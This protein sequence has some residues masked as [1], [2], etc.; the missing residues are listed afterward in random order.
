M[1]CSILYY[2]H[3]LVITVACL[4]V[5]A[6]ENGTSQVVYLALLLLWPAGAS[7]AHTTVILSH[8]SIVAAAPRSKPRTILPYK[9][10]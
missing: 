10:Q 6:S 5:C 9:Q 8:L 3:C 7:L 1:L 2:E 4:S